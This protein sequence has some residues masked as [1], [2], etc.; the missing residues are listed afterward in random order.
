MNRGLLCLKGIF[1]TIVIILSN[2]AAIASEIDVTDH[3]ELQRIRAYADRL[4]GMQTLDIV[5]FNISTETVYA[6]IMAVLAEVSDS[7]VTVANADGTTSDGKPYFIYDAELQPGESSN[8]RS[9]EFNNPTRVRYT[10]TVQ[11]LAQSPEAP[12]VSLSANPQKIIAGQS[13][14]L[15][16]TSMWADACNIEP[17][18]REYP[19]QRIL[20][21]LT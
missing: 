16:W 2:A 8:V 14:T 19:S 5:L 21:S 10:Y 7:R 4:T 12:K 3:I 15:T 6:P 1:M 18:N 20:R 9:W 13:V 11:V 17:G